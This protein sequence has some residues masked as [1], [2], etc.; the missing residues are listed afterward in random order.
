M[1]IFNQMSTLLSFLAAVGHDDPIG[2]AICLH[3]RG[4][5]GHRNDVSHISERLYDFHDGLTSL[6]A[7]GGGRRP[8]V[9]LDVCTTLVSSYLRLEYYTRPV[10]LIKLFK[11]EF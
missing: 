3:R 8:D 11:V 4:R 7:R 6:A 1:Y 2:P 5:P 9:V 10:V